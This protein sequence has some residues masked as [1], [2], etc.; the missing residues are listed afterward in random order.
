MVIIIIYLFYLAYNFVHFKIDNQSGSRA[1]VPRGRQDVAPASRG[2]MP[3][4]EQ[5]II[6]PVGMCW[7]FLRD[8]SFHLTTINKVVKFV[9]RVR[10]SLKLFLNTMC[11]KWKVCLSL[12]GFIWSLGIV[13]AR[14][15]IIYGFLKYIYFS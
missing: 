2:R 11:L 1:L 7:F 8:L 10:L 15:F 3:K 13:D 6:A 5:S 9:C 4:G 14:C 12:I